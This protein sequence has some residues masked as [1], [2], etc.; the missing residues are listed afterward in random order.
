MSGEN[1]VTKG[2]IVRPPAQDGH[3][4]PPKLFIATPAY[5]GQITTQYMQ[6][7][8]H[9]VR[10]LDASGL[11]HVVHHMFNES[12]ITRARNR[13]VA[14]FLRTDCT[15]LLFI[16]ADVGFTAR[17]VKY[18]V[19]SDLEVV[20]GCYPMKAIGWQNVADAVK[21]DKAIDQLRFAG[22]RYAVNLTAQGTNGAQVDV[23]QR[24][25]AEFLEVLDAATGFLLIK[26]DVIER[27]IA[28]Y[29]TRIEYLA[30]YEPDIGQTHHMV[31]QADRDPVALAKGEP[32][33]YL[34]EDYW[35]SRM[36][37][38]MGGKIFLCLGAQL[39]HT[40]AYTFEGRVRD[41]LLLEEQPTP[42][43]VQEP[44]PPMEPAHP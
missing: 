29:K 19:E 20:C 24:A 13:L 38:M 9:L 35:F 2:R 32:A 8:L 36:W 17:D 15:H 28:A 44:T 1:G 23:H 26:R 40:G 42:A 11:Q 30:D 3:K 6:G 41:L 14:A 16:D 21:A 34:S 37:Q 27:F 5:G 43:I 31:F 25:G 10:S 22:A 7:L 18:L 12:L 39:T 4:A 33:R